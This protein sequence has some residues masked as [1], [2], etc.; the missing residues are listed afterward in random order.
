MRVTLLFIAIVALHA[1]NACAQEAGVRI[2]GG[3]ITGNQYRGYANVLQRR[4]V[5][6]VVDGLF[7]APL[8]D[9]PKERLAW[10]ENCVV[11]KTDDQV[12]TLV[13]QYLNK[14]RVRWHESMHVLVYAG[15]RDA[16]AK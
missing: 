4:Y 7:L 5:M 13:N 11:G 2:K 16:C 10:L 3:F 8:L 15:L 9:A 14:N 12:T 6:G 1:T